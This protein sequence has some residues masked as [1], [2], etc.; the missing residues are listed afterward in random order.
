[1]LVLIV[2]APA[3][4]A[5]DSAMAGNPPSLTETQFMELGERLMDIEWMRK[6]GALEQHERELKA[7]LAAVKDDA[8]RGRLAFLLGYAAEF[9]E[10]MAPKN[11]RRPDYAAAKKYYN[12]AVGTGSGY[13]GQAHYRLGVLGALG[14][15]DSRA[16]SRKSAEASFRKIAEQRDMRVWVR[17]SMPSREPPAA[18][19]A[20]ELAGAKSPGGGTRALLITSP[21]AAIEEGPVL[22]PFSLAETARLRLETLNN[23]GQN[24]RK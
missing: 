20:V 11:P 18:L 4:L 17:H 14:L 12:Q 23:G 16:K 2:L 8:A 3:L 10:T 9:R 1:M 21:E 22:Q 24:E 13:A 15:L 7:R 19:S 5:S 6:P